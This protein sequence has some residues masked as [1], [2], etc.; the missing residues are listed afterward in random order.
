MNISFIEPNYLWWLLALPLV[1]LIGWLGARR[2]ERWRTI[3]SIVLRLLIVMLL[4]GSLAGT[5]LVTPVRQL[6]TLFLVDT[7]DSIAPNQRAAQDQFIADAL[8]TMP[9]GDRAAII[10]FGENA[11]IERLPSSE[12]TLTVIQSV[13]IVARTNIEQALTLGFALF[14]ADSQKRIVL[15]SDGGENNGQALR[16]LRLARERQ[17]PVDVV[18]IG[19]TDGAEVAL[20]TLRMP[21][22]ARTGQ[23]IQMVALI[24]SNKAQVATVRFLIDRQQYSETTIEL[25]VG[26]STVTQ[27]VV[28]DDVG[29]HRITAQIIPTDDIRKQNN[30]A[31]AL[32]NLSGKPRI[33]IVAGDPAD[34]ETI[35]SALT[36]TDI[37]TTLVA[38]AGLPTSLAG[39]ADYDAV[40]V[41][42]VP[43]RLMADESQVALRSYVHDLGR[44]FVMIG[45]ENSYGVGGYTGTPIEELLPV[46]MQLRNREKF[47]PVSV[48]VVFDISGSM[49][50]EVGGKQK[51]M[52]AAEGAARVVQL[53]RD[54]DEITV[55][56][57]DSAPQNTYGPVSG[58]ERETAEREIIARGVPG[59]GGIA[60]HDSLVAAGQ[61]VRNRPAPLK[62]IILLAD[63]SDS[64]QQEGSVQLVERYKRDGITTSVIAI[65]GGG[66]ERFLESVAKAGGGRYFLVENATTLP[67]VILQD[68]QLSLAPYL[69][70]QTFLPLLGTDSPI[71]TGLQSGWTNLYGY[72]GT[73]P[74]DR[75]SIVLWASDDAP[76]LAQWQYGLG[77]SVAWTSDMKGKWAK[78]LIGWDQFPRLIAQMVG[79]T[80]PVINNDTITVDTTFVGTELEVTINANDADDQPM[81]GM[82]VEA[83]IVNDG[84]VQSSLVL[85]EVGAGVYQGRTLSPAAGTYFLQIGGRNAEGRAMF[86]RTAGMIVPYSPEY[87]QGQAN[88][89]LLTQIAAQSGGRELTTP[90]TV[91]DHSLKAVTR[92]TPIGF[93]L[94][95]LSL[96]LFLFDVAIRRLRLGKLSQAFAQI[97]RARH[98]KQTAPMLGD[99][100]AAKQRA[101]T[102]MTTPDPQAIKTKP[103]DG[104]PVYQPSA[105]YTPPPPKPV[106]QAK[107]SPEPPRPAASMPTLNPQNKK[108]DL[109]EIQDPL[110]RLRAAKNRARRQ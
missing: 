37:E 30:E 38:P 50:V 81:T 34:G 75:A 1:G 76:L 96:L 74:K 51:V 45:G 77:R 79:W 88:P 60:V 99:L 46:D 65:G 103:A 10:V 83:N 25:P 95:L 18:T 28:L 58:A 87:R 89:V 13:P 66:D 54:F 17:I 20:T 67:D 23:E 41:A 48:V 26:T 53:L 7:S 5:Q 39:L 101:R 56:P 61:A 97:R 72:N 9:D 98:A 57:F 43:A 86:Q 27:T 12:K 52:L 40:I 93:M 4:V 32:I 105:D 108:V 6:T 11:L 91:F 22:Q 16:A 78:D 64:Q 84:G 29:Y 15:L 73:T 59:G 35:R 85:R 31:T 19:S 24:D 33:L 92:A 71:M 104:A 90:D 8:K 106:E 109:D 55:I 107:P 2:I 69:V 62:H 102:S 47:P 70:E 80:L 3:T 21:T 100:A 68:A 49:S 94:L 14:P 82:T 44:G 42:N 36:A 110:E 63:G